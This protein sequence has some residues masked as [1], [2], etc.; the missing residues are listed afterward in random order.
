MMRLEFNEMFSIAEDCFGKFSPLKK[1]RIFHFCQNL[2]NEQLRK[3]I[4]HFVDSG[5]RPDVNHFREKA[6]VLNR[7]N[8]LR[9]DIQ[10]DCSK[11]DDLGVHELVSPS[12]SIFAACTCDRGRHD[13]KYWG[14]KSITDFDRTIWKRNTNETLA[15][16]WKPSPECSQDE[17]VLLWKEKM[18]SSQN[19]LDKV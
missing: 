4:V 17:K 7:I 18:R 10:V 19:V 11:C 13:Q 15:R 9:E 6:S 1:D 8:V 2:S 12:N 5:V 3:L 14:I 16:N